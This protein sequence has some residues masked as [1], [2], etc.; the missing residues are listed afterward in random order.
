MP[1]LNITIFPLLFSFLV[2]LIATPLS[3]V[4]L[5]KLNI[6]DDPKKHNHPAIIHKKPIP[7]G[8]GIPLFIG[9][10][11]ASLIFLPMTKIII[12]II[13]V[14]NVLSKRVFTRVDLSKNKVYT[15]APIS[16]QIVNS[17]NDKL[18]V[19]AYFSDNLPY[20]YNNLRRQIYG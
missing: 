12:A 7:R 4:V 8:G 6:V 19:K 3:L 13:I 2:T 16:K 5:K 14:V 1:N 9:V 20:P 11:I 10:I 18:V 15:L 17:L